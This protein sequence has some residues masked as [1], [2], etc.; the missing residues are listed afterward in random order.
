LQTHPDTE[1][2]LCALMFLLTRQ[3]RSPDIVLAPHIREHLGWLA[4]HPDTASQPM[5]RNTCRRLLAHWEKDT[6]DGG[7]AADDDPARRAGRLH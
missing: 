6:G 3:V 7:A 1:Q 2:L 4:D 5:L